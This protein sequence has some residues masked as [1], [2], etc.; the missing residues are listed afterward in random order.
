MHILA[1]T[2]ATQGCQYQAVNFRCLGKKHGESIAAVFA[3]ISLTMYLKISAWY[4]GYIY[5]KATNGLRV[6]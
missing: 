1:K 6:L 2:L 5:S 3:G 4:P